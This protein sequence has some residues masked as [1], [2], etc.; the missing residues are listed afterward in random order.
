[1]QRTLDALGHLHEDDVP[2]DAQAA[3]LG[4]FRRWK[5]P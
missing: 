4:A 1:M 2:V 3:L 5:M